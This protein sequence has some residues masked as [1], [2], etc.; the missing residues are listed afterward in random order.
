MNLKTKSYTLE[1]YL[2]Q[3]AQNFIDKETAGGLVLLACTV[4]ALVLANSGFSEEFHH[5]WETKITF[6]VGEKGFTSSLHF[7]INDGLMVIFFFV[8]GLEIKREFYAGNLS[9]FRKASLPML[10]A[11]GG[12]VFPA[13]IYVAFNLGEETIHGWGVPMATDI[14]YS[15]GII[16]L[17]GKRVPLSLKVF[18]T[19]V[20]V[21]DDIG[22]VL[23][24]AVFYSTD[25][26]WLFLGI[27]GAILVI[28]VICNRVNL[29]HPLVYLIL[30]IGLWYA[31][32]NSGIHPTLAGVLLAFTIPMKIHM[33]DEEFMRENKK[34]IEKAE[35]ASEPE[36]SILENK[37]FLKEVEG[38]REDTKRAR[39]LALRMERQL[40][41]Y[42]SF[43]VMPVFALANAGVT[44][45]EGWIEGLLEPISLG[46]VVGL[47][48]GKVLGIALF[49][50]AGIKSKISDLPENVNLKGIIGVGFIAGI[51][52]T[53]SLFIST[54]A[55][56]DKQFLVEAKIAILIAS[57]IAALIGLIYLRS[58]FDKETRH[59]DQESS[60]ISLV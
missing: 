6:G 47:V 35:Q 37:D 36:K 8:V 43:F 39:P 10:A 34:K 24:I 58:I 56:T 57:F 27:G 48:V 60:T 13:L 55:F 33:K 32:L 40:T 15:L 22:A 20:A 46:I 51:G 54:L 17:L 28:A 59:P 2:K 23:V 5:F 44:F 16:S 45:E 21:V 18:L 11:L 12:I 1:D 7:L 3:A 38:I 42:N 25:I 31:F 50:Y 26:S 19:A 53:M 30:G 49:S 9:G 52:F 4:A 41:S 14:A 29:N